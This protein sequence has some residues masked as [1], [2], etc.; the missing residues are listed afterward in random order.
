[1]LNKEALDACVE[2]IQRNENL[3]VIARSTG[4]HG[5]CLSLEKENEFLRLVYNLALVGF[6]VLGEK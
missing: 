2:K 5:L 1:M 6:S 3:A 4:K